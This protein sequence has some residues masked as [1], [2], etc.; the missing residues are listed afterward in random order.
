MTGLNSEKRHKC[1]LVPASVSLLC[2][3]ICSFKFCIAC[4]IQI[5]LLLVTHSS[6][7][8]VV[9]C[10]NVQYYLCICLYCILHATNTVALLLTNI[11]ITVE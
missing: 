11:V 5:L 6:A 9:A 4:A 7:F 8:D 2:L 10:M 3:H 1:S